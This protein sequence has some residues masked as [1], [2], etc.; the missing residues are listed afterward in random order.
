MTYGAHKVTRTGNGRVFHPNLDRD[1]YA[2]VEALSNV[3]SSPDLFRSSMHK[4]GAILCDFVLSKKLL[5]S[6]TKVLLAVTAEDADFLGKG[7]VENLAEKK[8]IQSSLAVFWNNHDQVGEVSIA[9]IVNEFIPDVSELAEIDH[10][11]IAKSILSGSCV[12]KTNLLRL[13]ELM[14]Q[15][16]QISIA[17]PVCHIES[18][19]KLEAEFPKHISQK[20]EYFWLAKDSIRDEHTNIVSPGIGGQV[21]ERLDLPQGMQPA[22]SGYIPELVTQSF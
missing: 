22:K 14:P 6:D 8:K 7:I 2:V 18:F 9:P 4:A 10:L 16:C 20:F 1:N 19:E 5:Q 17:A 15:H 3:N 11:I 13:L 12:V 21:Y